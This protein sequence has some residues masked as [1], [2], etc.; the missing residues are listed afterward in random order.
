MEG[1]N[2]DKWADKWVD[3]GVDNRVDTKGIISITKIYSLS[4]SE[5]TNVGLKK[6]KGLNFTDFKVKFVKN[7]FLVNINHQL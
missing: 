1:P 4:S 2:T 3:N 5:F 7:I 6:M